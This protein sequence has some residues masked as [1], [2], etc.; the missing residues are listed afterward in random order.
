MNEEYNL[1]IQEFLYKKSGADHFVYIDE[2]DFEEIKDEMFLSK[3]E[4]GNY[5]L[6]VNT[7][8]YF[9]NYAAYCVIDSKGKGA[10]NIFR[11]DTKPIINFNQGEKLYLYNCCAF[12]EPTKKLS[13]N[14]REILG[15]ILSFIIL[16]C[17]LFAL[18]PLFGKPRIF[19][20]GPIALI[21]IYQIAKWLIPK[22]TDKISLKNDD[23]QKALYVSYTIG[24]NDKELEINVYNKRNRYYKGQLKIK[25]ICSQK[26]KE[27]SD[28]ILNIKQKETDLSNSLKKYLFDT[29]SNLTPIEYF[30]I[31]SQIDDLKEI[32]PEEYYKFIFQYEDL[33]DIANMPN[34]Q[35]IFND[36][37]YIK[38][39]NRFARHFTPTE[40][41]AT[42]HIQLLYNIKL[43]INDN[44]GLLD[45]NNSFY[46][47]LDKVTDCSSI[48]CH[49][50][51]IFLQSINQNT[52]YLSP[53]PFAD[54][55]IHLEPYVNRDGKDV[56]LA[57]LTRTDEDLGEINAQK[58][59]LIYNNSD[60]KIT[61]KIV[62]IT[63]GE[64]PKKYYG[65]NIKVTID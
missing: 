17:A 1:T 34:D 22:L 61:A 59:E 62:E 12:T 2:N 31:K 13:S 19:L 51:Q 56:F 63:G 45:E 33:K 42:Q 40:Y 58:S 18:E 25:E 10:G 32:F 30:N 49:S 28:I 48:F 11:A 5:H 24:Q 21:G 54:F 27:L 52:D 43:R 16:L 53:E 60:H 23:Y 8:S 39:E 6:E 35:I 20:A 26:A 9:K 38:F 29:C 57:I 46:T 3:D 41:I 47:N 65:C 14:A 50:R 55:P 36:E 15:I 64:P 7:D 44:Y 4:P 37:P